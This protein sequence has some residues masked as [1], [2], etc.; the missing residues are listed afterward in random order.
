M[1]VGIVEVKIT[2]IERHS[3]HI[4]NVTRYVYLLCFLMY[5]LSLIFLLVR[6]QSPTRLYIVHI[7]LPD[8]VFPM[9]VNVNGVVVGPGVVVVKHGLMVRLMDPSA[10]HIASMQVPRPSVVL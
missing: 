5:V 8:V 6:G 9:V 1:V 10:P 4:L 2:V 3:S 7:F